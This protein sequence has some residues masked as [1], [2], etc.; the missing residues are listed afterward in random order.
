[1]GSNP[2][3][4]AT[5]FNVTFKLFFTVFNVILMIKL[6]EKYIDS[7]SDYTFIDLF[8]GIGAFRLA[9]ESFGSEC[10]YSID[11][12]KHASKVYETNF[13]ENPLGDIRLVNAKDIPQH[14]ILCAGF[15][16][17]SFSISG[18]KL[19]FNDTRGTLFFDILRIANHHKPKIIFLENVSNLKIHDNGKTFKIIYNSL[20][21]LGYTVY[22]KVLNSSKFGVPQSRKR[23]FLVCFRNDLD[24]TDFHFPDEKAIMTSLDDILLD[25]NVCL[26]YMISKKPVLNYDVLNNLPYNRQKPIRV[27][28]V[29]KGGQGDRIY[30]SKGHSITLSASSGGTGSK[31]G[32]YYVDGVIR[33]LHPR[34]TARLMGF[35]DSFVY[36]ESVTQAHKQFGNSIVVDVLQYILCEVVDSLVFHVSRV[37]PLNTFNQQDITSEKGSMIAKNGF[38]NE[39]FVI[40]KFYSF[41]ND[42]VA[43]S[44]LTSMGYSIDNIDSLD[45][46]KLYGCKSDIQLNIHCHDEVFTENI[47]VKLVSQNS[48]YNQIDKRWV[49]KYVDLWEIPEDVATLLRLFSGETKSDLD[50]LRDNRRMF[51]DEFS[52]E[53]QDKILNFFENNKKR[54]LADILMGNDE[55]GANWI[56]VI[57]KYNNDSLLIS[58]NDLISYY[59]GKSFYISRYG[60]LKIGDITL[61]RKGGDRGRVTANM[62]QFKSN[63]LKYF[64]IFS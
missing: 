16:C 58:T 45:A 9:L 20:V 24:Y 39:E 35:Q 36:D 57:K 49:G 53:D 33:K 26:D 40:Q 17:Q 47:Q 11:I 60:N 7:L 13:G 22:E 42:N 2:I 25:N 28:I 1:M 55:F 21:N 34:E 10:V 32:L 50:N 3:L 30:S 14:D 6:Q 8:C 4:G 5:T 61:Q 62:L 59:L 19:G 48:G 44:W 15:P 56:L 12:D 54:I 23:I 38:V 37:K 43:S 46:I 52:L 51:M 27:G 64:G 31:T 18:K 41:K 29:N 63:P